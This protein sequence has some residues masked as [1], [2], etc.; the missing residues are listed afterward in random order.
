MNILPYIPN[1][2]RDAFKSELSVFY[3]ILSETLVQE[4]WHTLIACIVPSLQKA[5]VELSG[6]TR[7]SN[8]YRSVERAI[9][10]LL[11]RS[12]LRTVSIAIV[13]L[14]GFFSLINFSL[15]LIAALIA[16]TAGL[17]LNIAYPVVNNL[18]VHVVLLGLIT[19][20]FVIM[21]SI[22]PAVFDTRAYHRLVF[23]LT[24]IGKS[25]YAFLRLLFTILLRPLSIIVGKY[26]IALPDDN[27]HDIT[28]SGNS[29]KEKQWPWGIYTDLTL[30]VPALLRSLKDPLYDVGEY[31]LYLVSTPAFLLVEAAI[32]IASLFSAATSLLLTP[33]VYA[34]RPF[35][36]KLFTPATFKGSPQKLLTTLNSRKDLYLPSSC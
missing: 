21:L 9:F 36:V 23:G 15:Y 26:Y 2:S 11:Y 13:I 12:L 14:F 6:Y 20:V 35:A 34:V 1:F 33:A 31:V 10:T 32:F 30:A 5:P 8:I 3:M 17:A 27:T 24:E 7:L 29:T 19:N 16:F 28:F 18:L 4:L 22:I 25:F